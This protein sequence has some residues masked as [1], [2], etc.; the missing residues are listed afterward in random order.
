MLADKTLVP[1]PPET[2][3]LP[4]RHRISQWTLKGRSPMQKM[5]LCEGC[6]EPI[7]LI[8]IGSGAERMQ[9]VTC[10]HCGMLLEVSWPINGSPEVRAEP[11]PH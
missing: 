7:V 6:Q 3:E 4:V 5:I 2:A 1:R 11:K 9:D 10:E 8:G